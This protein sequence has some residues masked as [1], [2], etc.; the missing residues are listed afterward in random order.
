MMAMNIIQKKD[1]KTGFLESARM[2]SGSPGSRQPCKKLIKDSMNSNDPK[3]FLKSNFKSAMKRLGFD[4][5]MKSLKTFKV[6][7][8]SR[9]QENMA[10]IDQE[11]VQTIIESESTTLE[12]TDD[13]KQIKQNNAL[14]RL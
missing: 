13:R 5:E 3:E 2:R 11:Q 14:D 1:I 4:K 12:R 7:I 10:T 8:M 6:L 9:S